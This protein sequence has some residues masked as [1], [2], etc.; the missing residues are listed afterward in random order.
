VICLKSDYH[1]VQEYERYGSSLLDNTKLFNKFRENTFRVYLEPK[2]VFLKTMFFAEELRVEIKFLHDALA[3]I[4]EA[5]NLDELLYMKFPVH[6]EHKS[7]FELSIFGAINKFN[8]F[9]EI[10]ILFYFFILF[11][12]IHILLLF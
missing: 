3:K 11:I 4:V 12:C 10:N 6:A 1:W 9:M 7:H 8:L 5:H 2:F